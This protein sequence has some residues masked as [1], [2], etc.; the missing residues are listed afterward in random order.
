[1]VREVLFFLKQCP[2]I[3]EAF[4]FF[5]CMYISER[6][7]KGKTRLPLMTWFLEWKRRNGGKSFSL[8]L[9]RRD[10]SLLLVFHKNFGKDFSLL[11]VLNVRAEFQLSSSCGYKVENGKQNAASTPPQA[12]L[13]PCFPG[14][15][16]RFSMMF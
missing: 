8:F 3:L 16:K 12:C 4:A 11:R 2:Y 13:R 10:Y 5:F 15:L 7:F 1:M 9:A 6:F 14:S